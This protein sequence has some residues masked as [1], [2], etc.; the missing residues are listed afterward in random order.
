MRDGLLDDAPG[1]VQVVASSNELW[2]QMSAVMCHTLE[3]WVLR[4]HVI[5]IGAD[6]KEE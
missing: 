6:R 1:L 5:C 4:R 3:S 2:K